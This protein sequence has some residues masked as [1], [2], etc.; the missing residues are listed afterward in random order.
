MDPLSVSASI[1]ALL[2][3]AG[4]M[5]E[6]FSSFIDAPEECTALHTEATNLHKLLIS[7]LYQG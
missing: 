7:L 1:I 5:I 6:Y 3:A 2:Q 4:G